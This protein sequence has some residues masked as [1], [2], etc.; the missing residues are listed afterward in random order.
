MGEVLF[1]LGRGIVKVLVSLFAAAGVGFLVFGLTT[2][3]QPNLL[4]QGPPPAEIFLA[5][6]AG[7][8]TGA[9]VLLVLFAIPSRKSRQPPSFREDTAV[10]EGPLRGG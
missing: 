4:K 5:M 8:L 7:A 10:R 6:G 9:V 1:A 2:R 3:N